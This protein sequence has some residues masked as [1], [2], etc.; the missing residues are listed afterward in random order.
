MFGRVLTMH[1]RAECMAMAATLQCHKECCHPEIDEVM[2]ILVQ[3]FGCLSL[4]VAEF[5][6]S[7]VTSC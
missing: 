6:W 1:S 3:F 5:F 4:M 7:V 2:S